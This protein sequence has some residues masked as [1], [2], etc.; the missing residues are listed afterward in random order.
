[1]KIALKMTPAVLSQVGSYTLT[2]ISVENRE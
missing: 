1:M 2:L